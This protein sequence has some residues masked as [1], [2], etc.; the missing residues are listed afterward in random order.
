MIKRRHMTCLL[1][2]L[3]LTITTAFTIIPVLQT[4]RLIPSN[5]AGLIDDFKQDQNPRPQWKKAIEGAF[6]TMGVASRIEW[7]QTDSHY[8]RGFVRDFPEEDYNIVLSISIKSVFDEWY[9]DTCPSVN[10]RPEVTDFILQSVPAKFLSVY[11]KPPMNWLTHYEIT[12][13]MGGVFYNALYE[14]SDPEMKGSPD[15]VYTAAEAFYF[16]AGGNPG[17]GGAAPPPPEDLP[18]EP[19]N[20]PG[21]L[22]MAVDCNNNYCSDDGTKFLYDCTCNSEDG[23]CYCDS[24]PCAGGCD[25]ALGGCIM[26]ASGDPNDMCG[27]VDCGPD[28]CLD[29]GKT[30]M[31][32]CKCASDDGECYCYNEVCEA[33]C[34]MA[35]GRCVESMVI[36]DPGGD[37]N[38]YIYYDNSPD[39]LDT[40]GVI[41]GVAAGG[42]VLIGG[43][44]FAYK[45]IQ[46][47]LA[48]QAL[49]KASGA[50]V[51][52][53]AK[54]SEPSWREMMARAEET[55]NSA[56]NRVDLAERALKPS[57][58]HYRNIVE[59]NVKYDAE[60]AKT[61]SKRAALIEKAEFGVKAIKKGADISAELIGNVPGVGKAYVYGYNLTTTAVES[62]A[63]GDSL[64][65]VVLKTSSKGVE[66][67]VGD[68]LF[69]NITNLKK[70]ADN[71][72]RKT[73]KQVVKETGVENIVRES[74]KNEALND[75][76]TIAKEAKSR[77]PFGGVEKRVETVA[78]RID[79]K[80]IRRMVKRVLY[81]R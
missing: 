61:M 55:A 4:P 23:K 8:Y 26:Q 52:S 74:A 56:L 44:Y 24:T 38:E 9:C 64:G 45:G 46:G 41:G 2:M 34:N 60:W 20:F 66:T 30:R 73:V 35:T 43:G 81:S 54:V 18:S 68:K 29:D 70:M 75:F 19:D 47:V 21:D 1:A 57:E 5:P 25:D 16:A 67:L 33:G 50:A 71:T 32:D 49:K 69:G 58:L 13:E 3:I 42:G 14:H 72:V 48:R 76:M 31:Y 17:S 27:G 39:L 28:H 53:A 37:D 62:A 6:A 63:G 7:F 11:R 80:G 77:S 78:N 65:T 10:Y 79:R 12:W 40:L 59:R 22:C 15:P 36:D 51:K